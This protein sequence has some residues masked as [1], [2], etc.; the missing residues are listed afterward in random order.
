MNYS[1][2]K[3]Q[4]KEEFDNLPIFFAFSKEQF[5]QEM[6]KRGLSEN[7]V[8]KIYRLGEGF[9]A[10]YLKSDAQ[11][12][13]DF[14]DKP[15]KLDELMKDH[16]FAVSAFYSELWNH[17]YDYNV[18]Q[19]DWDVC[20]CFGS[21]QFESSKNYRDYLKEIGYPDECG[22]WFEEAKNKYY[23]VLDERGF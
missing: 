12:I 7:D 17:E 2:Y 22:D 15:D 4:R 13:R 11:I 6:E 23:K 20:S 3:K 18:Y 16:D 9:G 5:K 10:Y 8:D 14:Y 1:Q 19:G 21:C